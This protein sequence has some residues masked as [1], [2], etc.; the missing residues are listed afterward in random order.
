MH[1][2]GYFMKFEYI[3]FLSCLCHLCLKVGGLAETLLEPYSY[4]R[5]RTTVL[6]ILKSCSRIIVSFPQ[7]SSPF[8]VAQVSFIGYILSGVCT[9]GFSLRINFDNLISLYTSQHTTS[10]KVLYTFK[11]LSNYLLF[12]IVCCYK[13]AYTF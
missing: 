9:V 8:R 11:Q 13:F 12:N 3:Q 10:Y 2:V 6:T 7:F 4:A 1:L 5:T